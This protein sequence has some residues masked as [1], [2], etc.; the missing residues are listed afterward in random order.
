MKDDFSDISGYAYEGSGLNHSHE[1][2]LPAVIRHLARAAAER[3]RP[4]VFELGCGNGSV[5]HELA[6]AGYDVTG[7]DP[8]TEGIAHA[9]REYPALK[10]M[11]ASAYDDLSGRFGRF[12][13]VLSLEVVEHLYFPKKYA[14]T[15]Y[16]LVEPGGSA[17]IST[18]YHGYWKNL[19]MAV[20]GKIGRAHV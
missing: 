17:L 14:A 9:N 20:T 13:A 10:L 2:L 18:P 7:V 8:S 3:G 12:P 4:R 11:Q 15:L 16:D 19:A 1:Y 5:A 6:A